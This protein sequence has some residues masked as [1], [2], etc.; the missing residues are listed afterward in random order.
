MR[1]MHAQLGN[2]WS[3]CEN[4]GIVLGKCITR[5]GVGG[6][7]PNEA[8]SCRVHNSLVYGVTI[9]NDRL[10]PKPQRLLIILRQGR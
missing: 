4:Q 8:P 7:Y 5:E 1:Q 9:S 6:G 3:V 2:D 10:S